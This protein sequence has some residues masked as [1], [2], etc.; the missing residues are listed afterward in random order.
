MKVNFRN[1]T[2]NVKNDLGK[3]NRFQCN[4]NGYELDIEK[5]DGNWDYY[6]K[7]INGEYLEAEIIPAKGLTMTEMVQKCFDLIDNDIDEVEKD[8]AKNLKL[9]NMLRSYRELKCPCCGRKKIFKFRLDSDWATGAGDY[10]PVNDD[11]YYT[12]EELNFDSFDKPDID[13][14]HCRDCNTLFE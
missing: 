12:S 2:I 11:K 7:D 13:I 1:K 14:Y 6:V 4:W 5:Y 8:V 3:G 10:S 9:L